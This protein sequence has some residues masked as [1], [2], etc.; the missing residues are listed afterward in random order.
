MTKNKTE[1]KILEK[2]IQ[3][4]ICEFLESKNLFFW[5]QNTIPVF[6]RN[7]AGK[8]AFRSMGKY[9]KKGLPDIMI[10]RDGFFIGIEVKRPEGKLNADQEVIASEF[11]KNGALYFVATSVDDVR[12]QLRPFITF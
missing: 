8:M 10:I 3:R 1:K 4:E 9:A 2:D 12:A 6:S 5:R 11:I 7:N